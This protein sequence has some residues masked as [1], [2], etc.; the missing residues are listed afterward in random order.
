MPGGAIV[1]IHQLLFPP[2]HAEPFS[3]LLDPHTLPQCGRVTELTYIV[4]LKNG[5]R[6]HD[7]LTYEE[8]AAGLVKLRN[9]EV[10]GRDGVPIALRENQRCK[11]F[12]DS[13]GDYIDLPANL[14]ML[15]LWE[16]DGMSGGPPPWHA[17]LPRGIQLPP[18]A[19]F[20]TVSS[21]VTFAGRSFYHFVFDVLPRL[22]LLMPALRRDTHM[23][24]LACSDGSKASFATQFFDLIRDPSGGGSILDRV[25]PYACH[26]FVGTRA[27]AKVLIRPTWNPVKANHL[28]H[29]LAPPSLLGQLRA[30]LIG[31]VKADTAPPRAVVLASRENVTM[32]RLADGATLTEAIER[33]VRPPFHIVNFE[34]D[35]PVADALLLF[36]SAIVVVG[37]HGGALANVIAC[38]RRSLLVELGYAGEHTRHYG[39]AAAALGLEYTLVE[40]NQD[41]LDR[42]VSAPTVSLGTDARAAVVDTIDAKLRGVLRDSNNV[43]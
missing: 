25:S 20:A 18:P 32:R 27:Q 24:I 13:A 28:E 11:V 16:H 2:V 10:A 3:S 36:A 39:A 5:T 31:A 34:G 38:P 22:L 30:M 26:G 1:P 40:L 4:V 42:G 23:K 9:V 17:P 37:V 21:I 19:G 7:A 14:P 33:V 43:S 15:R 6:R 29:C 8:N 12:L 41:P 35:L